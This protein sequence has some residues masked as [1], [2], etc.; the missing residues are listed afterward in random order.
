[1]IPEWCARYVGL[2]YLPGG[3]DRNGVDCWGLA[4]MVWREVFGHDLP[5]YEGPAW[6]PGITDDVGAATR[7][8]AEAF[9]KVAY[10]DERCGD[11]V[12]IR[13]R[14]YPLHLALIVGDG[15]MLHIDGSTDSCLEPYTAP[16]WRS[17]LV[18][19]YRYD[20]G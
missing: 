12:V 16:R 19:F 11:G 5:A 15:M 8:Y 6:V 17:R 20:H 2:P 18:E 10:G 7:N 3:R 14:G 1:M 9:V 13:M 4:Q